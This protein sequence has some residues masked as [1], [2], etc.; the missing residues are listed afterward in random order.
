MGDRILDKC[1]N[2]IFVRINPTESNVPEDERYF[3]L[4]M[5]GLDGI[6]KLIEWYNFY[7]IFIYI[8]FKK[9]NIKNKYYGIFW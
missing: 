3:S 6:K 5:G 4:K 7:I 1:K 8:F 9:Y 2:G